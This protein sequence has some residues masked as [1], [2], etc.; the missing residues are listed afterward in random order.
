M[1]LIIIIIGTAESVYFAAKNIHG[2]GGPTLINADGWCQI[3]YSKSYGSTSH[4]LCGAIA[5]LAKI[6]STEEID[7]NLLNEYLSCRLIPL[8]KGADGN[9]EIGVRPIG[10]GEVI[11][12][13]IG[14]VVVNVVKQDIQDAVG[15]LQTCGGLK[16]GIE[17]SI[18]ATKDCWQDLNTE[19]VLL[20]DADNAFN[21]INR[22]LAVHNIRELCPPFYGY[23]KN[24]YQKPA[25]LIIYK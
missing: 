2:S 24:T 3:L 6:M 13:I 14:K 8:D 23:I 10:V 20:V 19:A 18:H 1:N 12:R 7:P 5:E 17:A 11:R 21:R 25:K 22:D 16:S 4:Q 9:G 15:P